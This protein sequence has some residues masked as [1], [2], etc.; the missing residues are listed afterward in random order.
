MDSILSYLAVHYN[1]FKAALNLTVAAMMFIISTTVAFYLRQ[2]YS[3]MKTALRMILLGVSIEA[4]G[5]GLHRL[6]WS[7]ESANRFLI[8]WDSIIGP[9]AAHWWLSDLPLYI[10]AF[11]AILI[12]TP[13]LSQLKKPSPWQYVRATAIMMAI[14]TAL[15]MFFTSH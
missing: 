13:I 5:W 12:V 2:H 4:F 14:T 7:L 10:A 9:N 6:Y 15:F 3:Q 1:E 11:G 8:D